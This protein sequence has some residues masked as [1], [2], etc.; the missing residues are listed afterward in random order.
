M[1]AKK[2]AENPRLAPSAVLTHLA[3]RPLPDRS[4]EAQVIAAIIAGDKHLFHDLIRPYEHTIFSMAMAL[5][6]NTQ[7]AETSPRKP[8]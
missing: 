1:D 2:S 8:F 3:M 7:E 5:L 6:R 4:A